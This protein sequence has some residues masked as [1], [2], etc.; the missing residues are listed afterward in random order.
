MV[1]DFHKPH[2][3]T[4]MRRLFYVLFF[5]A[6]PVTFACLT[7]CSHNRR[8]EKEAALLLDKSK[9]LD[10]LHHRLN[11]RIDSLWDATSIALDKALPSDFPSID[12][13]IFIKARNADHIRMFMSYNLLDD[14]AKALVSNAGAYDKML[15]DQVRDLF[16]QEQ[17]F[18]QE[19]LKFLNQVEKNDP[20]AGRK[21]ADQFLLANK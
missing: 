12:R 17:E 14:D 21:Y 8:W 15:A 2:K 5:I 11:Q 16:R 4:R 18:G 9:K 19:K 13:G 20:D 3:H 10:V 7:S 6:I 1:F